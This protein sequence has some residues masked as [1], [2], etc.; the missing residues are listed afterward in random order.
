MKK[1]NKKT[2]MSRGKKILSLFQ[3]A[4]LLA[5]VVGIPAILYFCNPEIIENFRSFDKFND[6]IA[7]YKGIGI[8]IYVICQIVQIVVSVLPGQVIQIRGR[9]SLRFPDDVSHFYRR[10]RCGHAD[11][12]LSGEAAGTECHHPHLRR[13]AFSQIP[14]DHVDTAGQKSDLPDLPDTRSAQGSHG[15]CCR[16]IGHQRF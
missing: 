11:H 9:I 6:W 13:G 1:K 2:G 16:G 4:L 12:I 5:I 10:S 15:L 7:Q 3:L 8:L 14:A